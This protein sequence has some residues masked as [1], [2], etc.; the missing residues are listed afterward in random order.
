MA[1]GYAYVMAYVMEG[2]GT[3]LCGDASLEDQRVGQGR[4]IYPG[5]PILIKKR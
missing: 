3:R 1:T 4:G 5:I 2:W